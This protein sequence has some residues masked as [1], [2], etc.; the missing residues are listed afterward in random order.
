MKRSTLLLATTALSLV[1]LALPVWAD[2]NIACSDITQARYLLEKYAANDPDGY[3]TRAA[4]LA[5]A[6]P[7]LREEIKREAKKVGRRYAIDYPR[8]GAALAGGAARAADPAYAYG[9]NAS[10]G[11][12]ANGAYGSSVPVAQGSATPVTPY[13]YDSSANVAGTVQPLQDATTTQAAP[14]ATAS[15]SQ[16][17]AGNGFYGYGQNLYTQQAAGG[18]YGNAVYGN[19]AAIGSTTTDASLGA[20]GAT[21]TISPLGAGADGTTTA[22]SVGAEDGTSTAATIGD[23]AARIAGSHADFLMGGD[24]LWAGVGLLAAGGT[25]AALIGS[26]TI[27]GSNTTV[28]QPACANAEFNANH[29]L[30]QI[31]AASACQRGLAGQGKTVALIDTGVDVTNSEFTGRITNAY[32]FIT[33]ETGQPAA[34]GLDPHG[35]QVAGVLGAAQNGVGMQGVAF[36]VNIEPLRVFDSSGNVLTSA[37]SP[38]GFA[39]A[40]NYAVSTGA[41]VINGSYGP[42]SSAI[43]AFH[44]VTTGSNTNAQLISAQDLAE[45]DAYKAAVAANTILVFAAGDNYS[46]YQ[47]VGANPTGPGFLPFIKPANANIIGVANGAY[48]SASG[49]AVLSTADYSSLQPLTIV[50]VGVNSNNQISSFSNRC[51]VAAAW[52]MAAPDE[53]IFTTTTGGGYTTVSGTSFAAPQVSAAAAILLAEFPNLTPTQVVQQLLNTATNIGPASIYGHGLLN[54]AAATAPTGTTGIAIQGSVSGQKVSLTD[55]SL[56]YGAAFG[57][58]VTNALASQSVEFL[59]GLDR[60]YKTSLNSMV[61]LNN[62]TFDTQAALQEFANPDAR[63]EVQ[64]GNKMS[65]GFTM[66]TDT[67]SDRLTGNGPHDDNSTG[68]TLQAFRFGEQFSDTLGGEIHYRDG[69]ALAIGFS[70][71][72]RARIDRAINKDSLTNPYASFASQGYASVITTKAFGGD[73]RVAGYFGHDELDTAARNFGSQAE[74][75]YAVGSNSNATILL[76]S[77]FEDNRVLGSQGTGAFQLGNGTMTV[78]SGLGTK[79]TLDDKTIFHAAGYAGYTSPNTATESLVTN[80][81]TIISS[82]FNASVERN[83]TFNK[84]D[85]FSLGVAQPLHVESGTM[86]FSLPYDRSYTSDSIYSNNFVQNLAGSG[87]EMDFEANYALS[88]AADTSITAG[89]LFRLDADQVAGKSD[90]LSLLRWKAKF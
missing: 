81:S 53:N 87:R 27:G 70:E 25:A 7:S 36:G 13:A 9:S 2:G 58:T 32:D 15:D 63:Q 54:L 60:S 44:T 73:V 88:L 12:Y 84:E 42:N 64:I 86:Q 82:A 21:G 31:N 85:S 67:T 34:S 80:I 14:Y 72:D 46:Q 28:V 89:T 1:C 20:G 40:I 62:R 83:G 52:C 8:C 45:A 3:C 61:S 24:L 4:T 90:L 65:L 56:S 55:S 49:A 29:A 19:S 37:Q 30:G 71:S 47:D 41:Q 38:T 11:G 66:L 50:V 39:P 17:V 35:T 68:A 43:T 26:G 74:S 18:V 23:G 51:G 57:S 76:G 75:T 6:N 22:A 59:D 10:G 33:N 48:R 78:Y 16:Q 5:D 69:N 79:L 77:L